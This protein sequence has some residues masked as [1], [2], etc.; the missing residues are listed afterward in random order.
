MG[1]KDNPFQT[2]SATAIPFKYN[3]PCL[4]LIPPNWLN[5]LITGQ[6][7]LVVLSR[8]SMVHLELKGE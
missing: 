7:L 3:L 1:K 6:T 8:L 2:K 4:F 5:N